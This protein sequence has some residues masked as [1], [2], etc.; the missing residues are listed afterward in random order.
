[1][2]VGPVSA[3]SADAA[4]LSETVIIWVAS[5]F[6][7]AV[8]FPCSLRRRA[9]RIVT[10]TTLAE[11]MCQWGCSLQVTPVTRSYTVRPTADERLLSAHRMPLDSRAASAGCLADWQMLDAAALAP[12]AWALLGSAE[13]RTRA[14][15]AVMTSPQADL[16]PRRMLPPSTCHP[17]LP[18]LS[19]RS[20]SVK[21]VRRAEG[22]ARISALWIPISPKA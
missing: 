8:R 5:C 10:F 16:T 9:L 3:H 2:L 22:L 17:V 4:L 11:S 6:C 21:T 20:L 19:A 1:M 15:P 14:S 13:H 12:P 18:A 7:A